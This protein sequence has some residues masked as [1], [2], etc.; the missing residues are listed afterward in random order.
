MEITKGKKM[1]SLVYNNMKQIIIIISYIFICI[2]FFPF[3][4]QE[5]VILLSYR[6][7]SGNSVS[8]CKCNCIEVSWKVCFW[9]IRREN[10]RCLVK[11]EG[12]AR[13]RRRRRK[14]RT[15]TLRRRRIGRRTMD[16]MMR[17]MIIRREKKKKK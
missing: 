6:A 2:S 8:V 17:R 1:K 7:T 3:F 12:L 5:S 10:V 9:F 16:S 13:R 15:R 4:Y 11:V 14:T